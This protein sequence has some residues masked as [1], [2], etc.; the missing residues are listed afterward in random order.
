MT[1]SACHPQLF[2]PGISHPKTAFASTESHPHLNTALHQQSWE[3]LSNM[4]EALKLTSKMNDL[5]A[6]IHG[7]SSQASHTQD[8]ILL[9]THT[10]P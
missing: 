2:K 7:Y 4:I 10:H 8:S 9:Y 5:N 1:L 3:S 6:D